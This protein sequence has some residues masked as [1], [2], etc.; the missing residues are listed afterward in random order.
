MSCKA[1]DVVQAG[2]DE[3]L[4]GFSQLSFQRLIE[5]IDDGSAE[6]PP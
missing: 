4:A 1:T 3:P 2:E 6:A 5:N